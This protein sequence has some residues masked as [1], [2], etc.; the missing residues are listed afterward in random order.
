MY[1]VQA[2]VAISPTGC[3]GVGSDLV[4]NNP[5]DMSFFSGF[6]Q[7]KVLLA[8]YNTCK[9]LPELLGREVIEDTRYQ[10][11]LLTEVSTTLN[12]QLVVI[13]GGVTYKKYAPQVEELYVTHFKSDSLKEQQ[14][15]KQDKVFFY[16]S[17]Y[18]H[19]KDKQVVMNNKDFTIIK[20]YNEG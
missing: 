11:E 10:I 18:K 8:G 6:T 4:Y 1:K 3:I 19:L 16:L 15:S 20:Y 7:G 2:I 9:G 14:A 12:Q 13:G 5:R 17:D